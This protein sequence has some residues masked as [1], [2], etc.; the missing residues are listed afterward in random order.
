MLTRP[1]ICGAAGAPANDHEDTSMTRSIDRRTFLK[2]T[3][4]TAIPLAAAPLVSGRAVARTGRLVVA[5]GHG[6]T[7]KPS[8]RPK[9]H[10]DETPWAF[11]SDPPRMRL[12]KTIAAHP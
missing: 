3:T 8:V 11:G 2:R 4:A 12:P 10:P 5:A 1:P 9:R 6:A 7:V